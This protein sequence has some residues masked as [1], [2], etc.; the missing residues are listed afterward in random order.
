MTDTTGIAI[1][2]VSGRMGQMLVHEVQ[3]NPHTHL[4]GAIERAG[5]DWVG[6]DL[7]ACM[8]VAD[9]GL[10]VTDDPLNHGVV[11]VALKLYQQMAVTFP[12]LVHA[13][14]PFYK[15]RNPRRIMD[16]EMDVK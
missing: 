11:E 10:L 3:Q 8:G 14:Y 4:A 5:H 2:G 9:L 15:E 12:D 13:L 16:M 6:R 1:T 7:G